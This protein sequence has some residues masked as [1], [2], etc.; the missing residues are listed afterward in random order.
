MM[1]ALNKEIEQI[2]IKAVMDEREACARMLELSTD[3]LLL[4]A[5]EMHADELRTVKAVLAWL[6][7]GI[8]SRK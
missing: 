8:R 1:S 4:A 2:M 7:R 3:E 6:A 5:G